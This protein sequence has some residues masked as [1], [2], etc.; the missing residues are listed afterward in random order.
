[1][2]HEIIP[3]SHAEG[4]AAEG[5]FAPPRVTD[6]STT[7]TMRSL[8]ACNR[9]F[10]DIGNADDM[11]I[12]LHNALMTDQTGSGR[13]F[14]QAQTLDAFFHRLVARA[15]QS[16]YN[17]GRPSLHVHEAMACL[18]L[19]AQS[20]CRKTIAALSLM[21]MREKRDNQTKGRQK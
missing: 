2:T 1:M 16:P 5:S 21:T 20:E 15:L 4:P 13:L 3:P 14:M 8:N 11:L 10:D 6:L 7:H 19:R 18:A 9:P 12:E 17:D